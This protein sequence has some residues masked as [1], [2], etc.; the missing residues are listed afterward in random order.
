MM[1]AEPG[2]EA[3]GGAKAQMTGCFLLFASDSHLSLIV[4]IPA[5]LSPSLAFSLAHIVCSSQLPNSIDSL[6]DSFSPNPQPAKLF[7]HLC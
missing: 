1:W 2:L 7:L 6:R 5:C 4:S 3:D